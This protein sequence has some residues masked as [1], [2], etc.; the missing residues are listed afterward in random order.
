MGFNT[1]TADDI[2]QSGVVATN[3]VRKFMSARKFRL[4]LGLVVLIVA[5]MT[6]LPYIV[7]DGLSGTS[8]SVFSSYIGYTSF[9]VM[10][11]ATLFAS[12][13]IVSE[14][15]ER[16]ALILFTRPIRRSS[17]FL[18]KLAACYVLV[19]AVMV[20]YYAVSL[21]I[22]YMVGG[23]MVTSFLP[24][25]AMCLLFVFAAS[26]VAMLVSSLF[27]KGG[28]SA[29]ITFIVILLLLPVISAVLS[30][31]GI[32]TWFMLD[33]AMGSITTSI[34]EYVA[35]SNETL[36]G[37]AEALGIVISPDMLTQP[38]DCLESGAVMLTWGL[39][40]LALSFLVFSRREF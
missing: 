34:P 26:G 33:S 12:Y 11:G 7:G 19:A 10:L 32:D 24:S 40:T 16:T 35:Q 23:T 39:V 17:I 3:E 8:G 2:R 29:V 5:L 22:A 15:E 25:L 14:F 31:A 36:T 13:T 4:Y 38:A 1:L 9:L 27:K 20:V 28:T 21:A 18:G 37:L 30:T 6:I